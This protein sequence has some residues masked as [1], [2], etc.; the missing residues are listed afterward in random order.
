MNKNVV[1]LLTGTVNVGKTPN[2]LRASAS[3]RLDD[4]LSSIQMWL[5]QSSFSKI[6]FVENSNFD[7]GE[8]RRNLVINHNKI[9]LESFITNGL[10]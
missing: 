9:E 1:L 3:Q 5:N 4:Y 7:A 8:I 6:L 2:V 10:I